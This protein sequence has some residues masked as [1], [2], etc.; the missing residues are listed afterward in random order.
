MEVNN[1]C[2]FSSLPEPAIRDLCD[3]SDASARATTA[4]VIPEED[5]EGE[6]ASAPNIFQVK[7]EAKVT[8]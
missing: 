6:A 8:L 1:V 3:A 7:K 2:P 5:E 4:A